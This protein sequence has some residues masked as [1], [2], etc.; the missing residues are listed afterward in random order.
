MVATDDACVTSFTARRI[1]YRE[2]G[3]WNSKN[4]DCR[5]R[6]DEGLSKPYNILERG[7]KQGS[8][9]TLVLFLLVMDPLPP[10]L[11]NSGV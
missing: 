2:T 6:V 9:L 5:V 8:I 4:A 11:E 7:L 1:K 10:L 3:S